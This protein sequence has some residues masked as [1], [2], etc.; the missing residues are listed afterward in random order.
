M[1][2]DDTEPTKQDVIC[3][4]SILEDVH[5]LGFDWQGKLFHASDFFEKMYA[6]VVSLIKAKKAYVC[7]LNEEQI[8]EYRGIVK[9]PGR[10]SP[11]PNRSVEEN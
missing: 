10:L 6:F 9:E 11:Y 1:R 4:H 8:G 2:F 3:E 5:W 7:H